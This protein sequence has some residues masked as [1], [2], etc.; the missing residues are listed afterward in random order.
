[1][2]VVAGPGR[3]TLMRI[4][5]SGLPISRLARLLMRAVLGRTWLGLACAF[6]AVGVREGQVLHCPL[7]TLRCFAVVG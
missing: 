2:P 1:M 3:S 7:H 4:A 5:H 6:C